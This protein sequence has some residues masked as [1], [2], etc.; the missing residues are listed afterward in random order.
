MRN[1]KCLLPGV[2]VYT[3]MPDMGRPFIP[4]HQR[5]SKLFPLRLSPC[6]TA[7]LENASRQ[8]GEPVAVILRKGA[9]LYIRKKGKDGPRLAKETSL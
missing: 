9:A 7:E 1:K 2:N 5:R 6:E 8:L 4:E 3:L